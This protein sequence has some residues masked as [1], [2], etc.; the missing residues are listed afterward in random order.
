MQMTS[1]NFKKR[2]SLQGFGLSFFLASLLFLV[3]SNWF[4]FGLVLL[5]LGAGFSLGTLLDNRQVANPAGSQVSKTRQTSRLIR[6]FHSPSLPVRFLSL[7]SLG[8]VLF[9]AAWYLSYYLLPEKAILYSSPLHQSIGANLF[10]ELASILAYN[11]AVL[12]VIALIGVFLPQYPFTYLIP[13]VWCVYYAVLLGTNSF[14]V[15]MAER[16]APSVAVFQ[17][18]GPFEMMA[19]LLAA[20]SAYSPTRRM[21]ASFKDALAV[22]LQRA[23]W[24]GLALAALLIVGA[25]LREALMI[26]QAG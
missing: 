13:L 4:S 23:Q 5:G 17:R 14:A 16:L 26:L 2:L 6:P 1:L 15:P 3:T 22:P 24:I 9:T 7:L 10:A 12:V 25:A 8:A 18:A 11:L 20:A 19:Y 21:L